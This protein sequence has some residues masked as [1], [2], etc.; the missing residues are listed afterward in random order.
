MSINDNWPAW[1][2]LGLLSSVSLP[3]VAGVGYAQSQR[4]EQPSS[5]NTD[6][7]QTSAKR[8]RTTSSGAQSSG[9]QSAKAQDGVDSQRREVGKRQVPSVARVAERMDLL[10]R[11]TSAEGKMSLQVVKPG[12]TTHMGMDFWS[13]GTERAL[14]VVRSPARDKG[15]STLQIGD[16]LWQYLPRISRTMRIP[17]S[18]MLTSWMGSDF[19][20][21]DLVKDA[22]YRDD[23]RGKFIGATEDG[24]HLR[25]RFEAKTDHAGLWKRIDLVLEPK[26]MVPTSEVYFDRRG[27]VARRLTFEDVT[28]FGKRRVPARLTMQ[29]E[30][31]PEQ[32]TV[33]TYETIAFDAGVSSAMFSLSQLERRR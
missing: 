8:V 6:D 12:R 18:M 27:R 4:G 17:P 25:Y 26:E 32:H 9:T 20:N 22:S 10:Y 28:S 1:A 29:T 31:K 14:I 2:L 15:I 19:T 21:D 16:D 11:S 3:G 23:Y 30:A 5:P 13:K 24:A 7:S 33:L